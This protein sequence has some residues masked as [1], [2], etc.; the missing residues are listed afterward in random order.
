M[1]EEKEEEE[2]QQ[3]KRKSNK[4]P[5]SFR[6]IYI[7]RNVV[8]VCVIFFFVPFVVA[9]LLARQGAGSGIRKRSDGRE[10]DGQGEEQGL[11]A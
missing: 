5:P 7:L 3:P 10:E 4:S 9:R 1:E 6:L 2:Q 11:F 8:C